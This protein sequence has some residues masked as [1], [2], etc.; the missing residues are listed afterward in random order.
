LGKREYTTTQFLALNSH[1]ALAASQVTSPCTVT[2]EFLSL[3]TYTSS[4]IQTITRTISQKEIYNTIVP[5]MTPIT[6]TK[7]LTVTVSYAGEEKTSLKPFKLESNCLGTFTKRETGMV[8]RTVI[9][10]TVGVVLLTSAVATTIIPE[11]CW[12]TFNPKETITAY[13]PAREMQDLGIV[14]RTMT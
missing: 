14:F 12:T 11:N 1:S 5:V 2:V 10:T 7:V 8:T 3:S 13:S 6:L 4:T 9:E